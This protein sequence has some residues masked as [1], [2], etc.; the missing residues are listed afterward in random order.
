MSYN[1]YNQGPGAE[2]GYGY[3]QPT[4][5]YHPRTAPDARGFTRLILSPGAC[6]ATPELRL[7]LER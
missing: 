3:A 5:S 2:S 6:D 7:S 1:P 4:V